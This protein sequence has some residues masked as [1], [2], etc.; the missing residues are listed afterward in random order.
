MHVVTTLPSFKKFTKGNAR[1]FTFSFAFCAHVDIINKVRTLFPKQFSRT[2]PGLFPGL[3]LI[4]K[5]SKIHINLYTLKISMLIL[6]TASHTIH[7]F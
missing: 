7:I 3:R 4:V 6:L 2:F 5:G 1:K